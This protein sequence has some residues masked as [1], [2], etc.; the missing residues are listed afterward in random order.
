VTEFGNTLGTQDKHTECMLKHTI[1]G[2]RQ[3]SAKTTS[4]SSSQ[5][6]ICNST[7]STGCVCA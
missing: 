3:R 1:T 5:A 2:M 6:F 7:S 4:H